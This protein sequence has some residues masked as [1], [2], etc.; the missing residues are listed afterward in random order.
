[1]CAMLQKM[2][3]IVPNNVRHGAKNVRHCAKNLRDMPLD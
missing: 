2:C 3:G 1:M